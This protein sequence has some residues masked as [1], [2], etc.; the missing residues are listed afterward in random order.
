MAVLGLRSFANSIGY[1]KPGKRITVNDQLSSKSL[2]ITIKDLPDSE[3][4]T[5]DEGL[6]GQDSRRY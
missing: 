5:S 3:V 1:S 4:D 6:T 2:S